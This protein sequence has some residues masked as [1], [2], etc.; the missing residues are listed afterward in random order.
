MT[1]GLEKKVLL[2]ASKTN[3]SGV[4]PQDSPNSSYALGILYLHSYLESRKHNVRSLLTN[5]DSFSVSKDKINHAI[6]E[7]V[8]DYIGIQIITQT[9]TN[10]FRMIEY[11]HDKYPNIKLIIGGIH[12]TI[13]YD[14]IIRKYPYIIIVIGEGEI[15][16]SEIIDLSSM[17]DGVAYWNGTD[18]IKTPNRD[19]IKNLDELPF[20]SHTQA[21]TIRKT[22]ASIISSR[23]CYFACSFCCLNPNVKRTIRFRS[24]KN[25]VDEIEY[26]IT[27][28][29][30]ITTVAF[31]DDMFTA[32]NNRV[33]ELCKEIIARKL[34]RVDYTCAA[35]FKP[36][37][38]EMISYMEN[39]GFK[40]ISFGL[41]SGNKEILKRCHKNLKQKDM[42]NTFNILKHSNI[43]YNL[44][45]I[46]GLPGETNKTIDETAKIIQN[47]QRIKYA[48]ITNT[49]ILAVYPGTEIYENMKSENLIDD[50]YWMTDGVTPIYDNENSFDELLIMKERLLNKISLLP[51]T[52]IR[53][54]NQLP[55]SYSILKYLI[56]RIKRKLEI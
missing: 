15:T 34:N 50:S 12:A 23:G 41:E 35:R 11:L 6:S 48:I 33:I 4:Q 9:R 17:P 36:F 53:I 43:E 1:M 56:R 26:V 20:P 39:A 21:I 47:L 38:K 19:V 8:P 29:P 13:M 51:V 16:F 42:I 25:V 54:I 45:L 37:H 18:V 46:V 52:P 22:T 30:H 10:A 55:N 24:V 3:R 28:F 40:A 31:V 27:N 2:R 44:Y 32:D 14:Q 7:E 5:E 49:T